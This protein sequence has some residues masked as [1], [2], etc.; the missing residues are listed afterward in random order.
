MAAAFA[1]MK[2]PSDKVVVC[3]GCGQPGHLK[4]DCFQAKTFTAPGVCPRCRK[5][6]HFANQYCSKYDYE[7]KPLL[8]NWS[9]SAGRRRAMTQ[10]PPSPV[11]VNLGGIPQPQ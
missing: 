10:I 5:G 2:G 9:Q 1:A 7:R 4:K 8:G 11:Q 3:Y 6:K